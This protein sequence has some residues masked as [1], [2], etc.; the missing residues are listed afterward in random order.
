MIQFDRILC[1]VNK[2]F[3]ILR[4]LNINCKFLLLDQLELH[5]YLSDITVN[6]SS[7]LVLLTLSIIHFAFLITSIYVYSV[8]ATVAAE[9]ILS[10]YCFICRI[11]LHYLHHYG[12]DWC[13]LNISLLQTNLYIQVFVSIETFQFCDCLLRSFLFIIRSVKTSLFSFSSSTVTRFLW[14]FFDSFDRFMSSS[15]LAWIKSSSS[16]LLPLL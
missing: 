6:R 8:H 13:F 12:V 14:V 7:F 9:N 15:L 11:S 10:Y 4:L 3:S 2:I 16:S 1:C 5:T